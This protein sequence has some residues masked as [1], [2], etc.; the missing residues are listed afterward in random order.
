MEEVVSKALEVISNPQVVMVVA[1]IVEF[2]LRLVKSDKPKSILIM[3]ADGSKLIGN[4]LVSVSGFLDKV[5][6]QRLK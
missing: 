3:I 4:A 1:V 6:G 5:I 2:A